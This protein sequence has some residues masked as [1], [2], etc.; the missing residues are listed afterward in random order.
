MK[1]VPDQCCEPEAVAG[2][3]SKGR[4]DRGH[5][6]GGR[7]REYLEET[8]PNIRMPCVLPSHRFFPSRP[9]VP[10]EMDVVCEGISSTTSPSPQ[11]TFHFIF[12]R[13]QTS[14]VR[15][16]TVESSSSYCSPTSSMGTR[17]TRRGAAAQGLYG[18]VACGILITR[19]WHPPH[20]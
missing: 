15:V 7:G 4:K 13:L 6:E 14:A 11:P 20:N 9:C 18:Y 19:N 17:R 10:E 1:Y 12:L 16:L 5:L 8:C 2:G 3:Y